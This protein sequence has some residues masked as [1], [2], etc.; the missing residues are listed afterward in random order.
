ML[1][2]RRF[3]LLLPL[4]ALLACGSNPTPPKSNPST[5]N[6]S[7]DWLALAPYPVGTQTLPTPI[8]DFMGALQFSGSSVTG[9]VRALSPTFPN[10]CVS[11]LQ[12]LTVTGTVDAS[13]N[14]VLTIPI[15]GGTAAINA[16]VQDSY[17]YFNGS[18]Q[19]TGGACAMG[20]TQITLAHF[21]PITGTYAG[22]FNILDLSTL[23][24]EP[25]TAT[26]IA[27]V[28]TQS[29]T[30][31]ADG[32]FP[33]TGTIT[34]TGNCS[35]TFA[36]TSE[37]VAGGGL[38]LNQSIPEQTVIFDGATEPTATYLSTAFSPLTACNSQTYSGTLT[39]Q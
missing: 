37:V 5:F 1:S 23:T 16:A 26:A 32:Q 31:N 34:A 24:I 7:G 28:L 25:G 18:W 39:R 2:K 11:A 15:S 33:V 3:T 21:A 20:S 17:A 13:N 6:L 38:M 10:P 4:A 29:T 14:L 36:L 12:D 22:T 30:P 8:A 19:I 27:A 35:G 9:T